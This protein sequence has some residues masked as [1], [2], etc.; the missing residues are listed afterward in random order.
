MQCL[1]SPEAEFQEIPVFDV[2]D[3]HILVTGSARCISCRKMPKPRTKRSAR[4][5]RN[6]VWIKPASQLKGPF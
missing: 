4:L 6:S 1:V 5:G 2:N 3:K